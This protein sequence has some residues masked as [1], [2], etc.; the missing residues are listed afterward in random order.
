M[1]E[2]IPEA[3]I[4]SESA[5]SAPSTTSGTNGQAQSESDSSFSLARAETR[6]VNRS[7]LLVLAVIALAAGALGAMIYVLVDNEETYNFET[8]VSMCLS[9]ISV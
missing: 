5:S 9:T 6:A 8:E 4:S 3:S 7:K 1:I 2:P